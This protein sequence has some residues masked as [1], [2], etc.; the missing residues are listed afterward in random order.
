MKQYPVIR[1]ENFLSLLKD[2]LVVIS[3]EVEGKTN[4]FVI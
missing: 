1:L 2:T 3:I 4:T